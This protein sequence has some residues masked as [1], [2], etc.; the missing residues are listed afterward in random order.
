[1]A[2]AVIPAVIK[3]FTKR[4]IVVLLILIIS[5][6][7]FRI[8]GRSFLVKICDADEANDWK[9]ELLS[10][11]RSLDQSVITSIVNHRRLGGKLLRILR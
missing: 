3:R 8:G 1:M 11:R 4:L 10:I 6:S 7:S 2:T 5:K 9:E